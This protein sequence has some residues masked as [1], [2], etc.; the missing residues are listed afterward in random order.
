[1]VYMVLMEARFLRQGLSIS[2]PEFP[3]HQYIRAHLQL[4]CAQHNCRCVQYITLDKVNIFVYFEHMKRISFYLMPSRKSPVKSF[5]E[6]LSDKQFSKVA[7]VLKLIREI[8]NVPTNYLKKL[9]NTDGIWEI[10][11]D[12]GRDT[13]RLLGFF[14]VKELIVLTNS[15]QKKTQKTPLKEIRLAESRKKE[16]LSRR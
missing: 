2:I 16:Y 11:V 8:D 5:L 7:W 14:D 10:R 6:T 1:M 4:C 15:F 13:F 3:I 12:S 9:V